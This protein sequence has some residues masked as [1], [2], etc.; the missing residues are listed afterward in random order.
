MSNFHNPAALPK[1]GMYNG[2]D[3][4]N[5]AIPHGL[6]RVPNVVH[7]YDAASRW[8]FIHGQSATS[9]INPA[10]SSIVVTAMDATNFYVGDAGHTNQGANETG[11]PYNWLAI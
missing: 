3:A 7:I 11:R 2:N 5:R 8:F 9:L 10:V 1:S 6:G 4:Q